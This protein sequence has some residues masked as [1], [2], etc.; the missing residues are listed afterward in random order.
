MTTRRRHFSL[1]WL[2]TSLLLLSTITVTRA[3]EQV[4]IRINAGGQSFTDADGHTWQ[5]DQY[6]SG[7]ETLSI[8]RDILKTQNIQLYQSE[9]YKRDEPPLHYDIPL[10]SP[11]NYNV[12][13]HF[14]DNYKPMHSV[15]ARVFDVKMENTTVINNLDIYK[16]ADN[17]GFTAISKSW[18]VQVED[19]M[20]TIE[21]ISVNQNPT[22]AGIEIVFVESL[23]QAAPQNNNNNN[24]FV[25]LYINAGSSE[26]INDGVHVWNADEYFTGGDTDS[27]SRS[28]SGT[29][30]SE[31]YQTWRFGNVFEYEIDVPNGGYQ[32]TMHFCDASD[33]DLERVFFVYVEGELILDKLDIYKNVGGYASYVVNVPTMVSDGALSLEFVVKTGQATLSAFAVVALENEEMATGEVEPHFAHA[34]PGGPYEKVDTD[35]DGTEWVA[36]DGYFSHT[37][38]PDAWLTRWTWMVNDEAVGDNAQATWIELPVGVHTLILEVEDSGGYTSIDYTTVTVHEY[39]F[40]DVAWVWPEMGDVAGGETI[41]IGGSGFTAS[42]ADTTVYLGSMALSNDDIII[43]NDET[44]E[45]KK[46]P[47]SSPGGV[48]ISVKTPKGTS[49]GVPYT[50]MDDT[51]PPIKFTSGTIDQIQGPTCLAFSNDGRYLFVGTQDGRITRFTLDDDYQVVDKLISSVVAD[52]EAVNRAILGIAI[53]PTDVA[54]WPT[55]YVSHSWLFHKQLKS[56]NGKVSAVSGPN[57]D[58][59]THV[60]TGLPV[61]DHDHG[62]NGIVFGNS[63][64]LYIQ[65]PGN[66]N[67]GVPGSLSSTRELVSYNIGGVRLAKVSALR[68]RNSHSLPRFK[69][70]LQ[71]EDLFSSATVVAYNVNTPNFDGDLDY[72]DNGN[73]ISGWSVGVFAPGQRNSYGIALHSNGYLYATDN[74]ANRG[75]G[76]QSVSCT[77]DGESPHEPDKLNLVLRGHFYGHANRKRGQIDSRQCKWR[78]VNETSD[79]EYTGPIAILPASSNGLCEFETEHFAGQLRGNLI[80]GRWKGELYN[81]VLSRDGL[82][83]EKATSDYPPILIE[84]GALDIV[85]GPDGTL[86]TAKHSGNLIKFYKPDEATS[87]G[88]KVKSVFPRRGPQSGGSTLTIYGDNLYTSG[89]PSVTVGGN[90]CEV[91]SPTGDAKITCTLPAGTGTA[92]IKVTAGLQSDVFKG[93]Y[94][95]VSV[96]QG[97]RSDSIPSDPSPAP[98]AML[99]S[100]PEAPPP[101]V[102]SLSQAPASFQSRTEDTFSTA[103]SLVVWAFVW[104]NT[105]TNKDIGPVTA[106]C[107]ACFDLSIPVTIRADTWG[108]VNSVKMTLDGPLQ[109]GAIENDMPHA[110]FG[111]RRWDY[112]GKVF[113]KGTYT[114]TAQAFSE[115][116]GQGLAGEVMSIDFEIR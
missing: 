51:L 44:I 105:E 30:F 7:G 78:S 43:V 42:A 96:D 95:Y 103:D 58:Q 66:T 110:L 53:D 8:K 69:S 12:T 94:R 47:E 48:D 79:D 114:V 63:G 57:L 27:T 61:S 99:S 31:L 32:V 71:E 26:S 91:H 113:E 111:D 93:G 80:I 22:V 102:Q 89:F 18:L 41:T 3:Q 17:Q 90:V 72:D 13:L 23:T 46:V 65:S 104:V 84:E 28:I 52:S 10:D 112:Q 24:N 77:E 68:S 49:T 2:L 45:V 108:E 59:L 40:P 37:H 109:F 33:Q 35:N 14:S 100:P 39:G 60:V 107:D 88:L 15:G 86:F 101:P 116:D 70:D 56:R 55:V 34:V 50:Y 92:D 25:P 16:E 1:S 19:E 97:G 76:K 4:P 6:F 29:P 38:L 74:G 67:A 87:M 75:Y 81:V 62:I 82:S 106:I 85:Q 20:L 11:G 73:Q 54:E 83:T 36:V 64:E 115:P 21:F 5:A 98:M 9:R